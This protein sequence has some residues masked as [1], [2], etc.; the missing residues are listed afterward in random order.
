MMVKCDNI[1]YIIEAIGGNIG[2]F[3]VR[4]VKHIKSE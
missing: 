3:I 4:D 1:R 2:E